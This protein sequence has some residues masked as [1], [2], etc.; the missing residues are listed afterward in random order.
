VARNR[1]IDAYRSVLFSAAFSVLDAAASA[2]ASGARSGRSARAARDVAFAA[3]HSLKNA[4]HAAR[5]DSGARIGKSAS[6]SSAASAARNSPNV[7][8]SPAYS[9]E[10]L[11][12]SFSSPRH[13]RGR[14]YTNTRPVFPET[15]NATSRAGAAVG[16]REDAVGTSSRGG[17]GARRFCDSSSRGKRERTTLFAVGAAA[18]AS[19]LGFLS[20]GG[21]S[22]KPG[23]ASHA[24]HRLADAAFRSV[25]LAH[26]HSRSSVEVGA[27][28]R[29]RFPSAAPDATASARAPK[30]AR[31]SRACTPPGGAPASAGTSFS[32]PRS[33]RP[34]EGA[35]LLLPLFPAAMNAFAG[36]HA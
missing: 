8:R 14:R 29:A 24:P 17:S 18:A 6:T 28:P 35:P 2:A 9:Q 32:A 11:D 31:M 12:V 30:N 15:S 13:A 7:N 3:S 19:R 25:H 33:S 21:S 20:G 34:E 10:V 26:A 1:S 4:R 5:R 27:R 36:L 16:R 22:E 23:G